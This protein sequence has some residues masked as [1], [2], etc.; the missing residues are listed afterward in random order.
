MARKPTDPRQ[1][2]LCPA[3]RR[4]TTKPHHYA[5]YSSKEINMH[6][7]DPRSKK[8]S[9]ERLEE[10]TNILI[11]AGQSQAVEALTGHIAALEEELSV[12]S[13]YYEEFLIPEIEGSWSALRRSAQRRK[14]WA[15]E[16]KKD[17]GHAR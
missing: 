13:Q 2:S 15:D 16:V 3:R 7:Q 5:T 17:D 9:K 12:L 1:P 4:Q 14:D 6:P 11:G 8:L 10:I